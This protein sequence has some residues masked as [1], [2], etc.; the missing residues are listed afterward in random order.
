MAT[1]DAV[2]DGDEAEGQRMDAANRAIDAARDGR[3]ARARQALCSTGMLPRTDATRRAVEKLLRPVGREPPDRQWIEQGRPF[4]LGLD[5]HLLAKRVRELG[6]GGAA[7]LAGWYSEHMQ[8]M[9]GSKED[10]GVLHR[11]LDSVARCRMSPGFYDTMAMGRVAPARKGLKNKVRPL[12]VP[13]TQRKVCETTL[14]ED[15]REK[16]LRCL[17][18]EQHAI[19]MSAAI[20]KLA[21]SVQCIVDAVDGLAVGLLDAVSAYNNIKREPILEEVQ[22]DCR[23]ILAFL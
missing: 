1:A 3:I 23:E 22:G 7:C 21:K 2:A 8:L 19:G 14:C 20:E 12:V 15:R 11:Y 10:F 5:P 13:D 6:K 4:A 9:L 16:F 18:P 17:G